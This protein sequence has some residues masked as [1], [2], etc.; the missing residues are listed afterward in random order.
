MVT[1]DEMHST[2]GRARLLFEM[3]QGEALTEGWRSE[4]VREALDLCLACKGCKGECPVNV[5][6]ATYKAEFLSHYY[7]GRMRPRTAYTMGLI[8]WWARLAALAPELV[9][10]VIHAPVL[11]NIAKAVA[12]IA[13]ERRIP[14]FARRT[15]RQEFR[16]RKP[17]NVG[18]P[19]V[20]LWADTFNNHFHPETALAAVEVLEAAGYQVVVPARSLCCGRPLYDFGMLDT[21]KLLLRQILDTLEPDIAAGTPVVG[22][23]PSCVAVFRDELVNLF[24]DDE[25]ARRL[26]AQSFLLSEFLRREGY[27]PPRMAGWALVHGHCH[28]KALM[29]M[30]DEEALL[31]GMGLDYSVLD[32]GCCGMAG[33]FGFERSH[34]DISIAAGERVLLPAVRAAN[35]DTLIIADGF[36]CREQ[37]AQTTDRRPLHIAEVLQRALYAERGDAVDEIRS[38]GEV[39]PAPGR[40]VAA[41]SVT[42]ALTSALLSLLLWRRGRLRGRCEIRRG[43]LRRIK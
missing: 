25:R 36:S 16:M 37:I 30:S 13:P 41:S 42:V 19:R 23:E 28:H 17:G 5:D 43:L 38:R 15:F 3:L 22:L 20:I 6:V 11:G 2:R 12:G 32:A 40:W 4:A 39:R 14:T 7:A 9:N 31:A 18:G 35:P 21:A 1:R 8:Y 33:A 26:A 24:P 27:M 29:K 34:Y 10:L